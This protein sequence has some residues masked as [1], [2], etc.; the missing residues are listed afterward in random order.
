MPP[1]IFSK[2]PTTDSPE[3]KAVAAVERVLGTPVRVNDAKPSIISEGFAFTGDIVSS[4][5]LHI[6]G[7][8]TG[9]VKVDVITI[10]QNGAVD[11]SIECVQLLVKGAL[12]GT[13]ECQDLQIESA[14]RINGTV[15]YRGISV[16]R[17][18]TIQGE[19]LL[20]K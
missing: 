15:S 10:G 4:G 5:T 8:I 1:E 19:L 11:G 16:Q 13:A 2:K 9:T 20:R 18:A 6:D 14:A 7:E 17:G 12:K 3:S